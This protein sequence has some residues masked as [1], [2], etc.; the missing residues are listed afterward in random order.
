MKK[1]L[2][3]MIAL[4]T[5]ALLHA[6]APYSRFKVGACVQADNHRLFSGCNVENASYGLTQCA[7]ATAIGSMIAAGAQKL[8]EIVV[9]VEGSCLITP[10]GACR[11][12]LCEFAVPNTKVHTV[13]LQSQQRRSFLLYDL[14]PDAFNLHHVI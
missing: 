3:E 5:Q 13:S 6:Y 11:Q 4:A 1:D 12:M 8:I 2:N 10:C 14:L 7:E 9:A